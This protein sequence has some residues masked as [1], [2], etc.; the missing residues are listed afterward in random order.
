MNQLSP[1]PRAISDADIRPRLRRQ[2]AWSTTADTVILDELGIARGQARV[3]L[4][5]VNGHIH[6]YE[7]KSDRDTLR[8]LDRQIE[9][10]G[11][12]FDRVTIVVGIGH[13]ND[14]LNSVPSWWGVL[15]AEPE[16][17]GIR[18]D[19][20][21]TNGAN[22]QI[23]TRTLVEF[24]WLDEALALLET[25]CSLRGLRGKP[26]RT[27]W[28]KLCEHFELDEITAHV[29]A[30]LKVRPTRRSAPRQS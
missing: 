29:R 16:A 8:R 4:A 6:G 23:D 7:I 19:V 12:V 10:Y 20:L 15:R 5:V 28:D 25:R 17:R 2:I 11:K 14:V 3:D 21:R 22:D 9:L 24:L 30:C 13:I 18:F 26:R 1:N 27:I